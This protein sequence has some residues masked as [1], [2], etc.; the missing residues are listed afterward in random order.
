[1]KDNLACPF[2]Q[3]LNLCSTG[4]QWKY[5][6]YN[7]ELFKCQKCQKTAKLYFKEDKL[8]HTIPST[9]TAKRLRIRDYIK[10]QGATRENDIATNLNLSIADVKVILKELED[11]GVIEKSDQTRFLYRSSRKN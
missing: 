1:M 10:T 7:V 2:C 9:R 6:T 4:K 11:N 5:A 8:S 3:S